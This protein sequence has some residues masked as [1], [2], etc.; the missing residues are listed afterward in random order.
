MLGKIWEHLE[1]HISTGYGIS[2]STHSGT[3]EKLLYPTLWVNPTSPGW[4][5]VNADGTAA[6]INADRHSWDEAVNT[7]R[8][9]TYVQ[10]ALK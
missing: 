7:Y 9:Y 6:Q 5:L 10:Q 8:T 3:A 4:A 2:E 1:H